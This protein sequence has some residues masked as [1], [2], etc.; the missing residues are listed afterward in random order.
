MN[1]HIEVFISGSLHATPASIG[2]DNLRE[3]TKPIARTSTGGLSLTPFPVSANETNQVSQGGRREQREGGLVDTMLF[4][5]F[6]H[7]QVGPT[8]GQRQHHTVGESYQHPRDVVAP[9]HAADATPLAAGRALFRDD[10][11]G[12]TVECNIRCSL[13]LG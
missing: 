13:S 11:Q 7:G 2:H 6:W 10:R 9:E 1:S 8:P 5:R 3:P 12:R 4:V